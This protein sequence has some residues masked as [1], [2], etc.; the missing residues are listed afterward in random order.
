MIDGQLFPV[1]VT[2]DISAEIDISV[3]IDYSKIVLNKFM[4]FPFKIPERYERIY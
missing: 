3:S 4:R 1:D 2:F